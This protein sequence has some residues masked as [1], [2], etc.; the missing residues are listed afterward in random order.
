[1]TAGSDADAKPPVKHIGYVT[2]SYMS[3]ELGRSFAMGMMANGQARHGEIVAV[4]VN[5]KVIMAEVTEPL[6][7]DK[8]NTRRDG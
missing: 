8:E 1:M 4:P 3:A 6:F 5:G 2:S 7:V